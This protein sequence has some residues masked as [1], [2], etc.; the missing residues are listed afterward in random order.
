M[1][2]AA[3]RPEIGSWICEVTAFEDRGAQWT[4]PVEAVERFQFERGSSRAS[5]GVVEGLEAQVRQFAVPLV[6]ECDGERTKATSTALERRRHEVVAWL[7]DREPL[8]HAPIVDGVNRQASDAIVSAFEAFM[9]ERG[10]LDMDQ[11]FAAT[12]VSNPRSG[13]VVRG[14]LI[15]M[16]EMGIAPFHG[17]IVRDT[18]TFTGNWRRE[19]RVEH[20]LWRTAFVQTMLVAIGLEVVE[21]HRGVANDEGVGHNPALESWSFSRK[22]AESVAGA[23]IAGR[24]LVYSRQVA[25]RRAFMAYLETRAMNRQ[26]LEAEAVLFAAGCAIGQV[27]T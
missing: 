14:H 23:P 3:L 7:A 2:V 8:P 12:Y 15:V 22:V 9:A 19:R 20:V 13:E 21:L 11:A 4:L 25:Y 16:A 24:P 1:R 26:F 17:T 18:S 27:G 10:L 5:S 6:I